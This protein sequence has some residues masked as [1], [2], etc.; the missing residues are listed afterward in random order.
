MASAPQSS[1]HARSHSLLLLQKLLNLRDGSSPL[2]LVLDSL[3]QPAQPSRGLP[4]GAQISKT[5]VIFLSFTTLRRPPNV[6]IFVKAAG[7]DLAAVKGELL[8]HYPASDPA[9]NQGRPARRAVVIID[10]INNLASGDPWS[11]TTF[12]PSIITPAV[13]TVSVYHTDVP[14]MLPK[15]VSEYEPHPFTVI[16]HLATAI[17]RVSSL[18]QEV[19]RKQARDRAQQEPEWGLKEDREGAIIGLRTK[20]LEGDGNGAGV[21]VELESR[22]RSGRAVS[23]KFIITPSKASTP[24]KLS[25][26]SDHPAFGQPVGGDGVA[27]EEPES[28]FDLGLTEKQRKDREGIVLPYFDA[29]TDIGGGEGGRI[30]YEMGREDMDDFDDEEDE[31]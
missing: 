4:S 30:L 13:S 24:G 9:R 25:L 10:S 12:L 6:D 21:V 2:T 3:E 5:V 19:L 20:F 29:Q 8:T 14:V 28:T 1:V 23:E 26:L 16:C 31:I 18:Q 11:M 15:T 7:R 17:V 22:R 27:E